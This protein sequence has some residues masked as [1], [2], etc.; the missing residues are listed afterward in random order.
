[1]YRW[2]EY[3]ESVGNTPN[4][5]VVKTLD[6]VKGR[7]AA[8]DL[9]AGNMRDSAFLLE[10]GFGRVVAV[11]REVSC[12]VYKPEGVELRLEDIQKCEMGE[13]QYDLVVCC[14]VF[15]HF[16]EAENRAILE[17]VLRALVPGGILVCNILGDRQ[18][19]F[20]GENR[21]K[22]N[23][24]GVARFSAGFDLLVV[25]PVES[26]PSLGISEETEEVVFLL[27]PV[28]H[29]HAWSLVLRKP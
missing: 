6:Y 10:Q 5:L 9:G 28:R 21:A 8:L 4:P 19:G 2:D 14:N 16:S 17:Q 12:V 24:E 25:N 18:E 3:Y 20:E 27:F 23:F 7:G 22:Y 13:N 26:E 11:E 15:L 29:D 1:V